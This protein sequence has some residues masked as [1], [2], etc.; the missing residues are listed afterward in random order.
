MRYKILVP[1]I[2]IALI[3]LLL[4]SFQYKKYLD[5][6]FFY[7]EWNYSKI[8]ESEPNNSPEMFHN[9]GQAALKSFLESDFTNRKI[10]QQSYDYFSWSLLLQEY[11]DTRFKYEF[12]KRLLE[13]Y[14]SENPEEEQDQESSQWEWSDTQQEPQNEESWEQTGQVSSW[15]NGRE[16][17]YFLNQQEE[18]Q[19]LSPRENQELQRSID[20]LKRDQMR[21]QQFYGK[22]QQTTPFQEA[23]DSVFW[24]IDRGW[25]KDW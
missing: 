14:G 22:Q 11:E 24:I 10:L 4:G 8:L 9:Y 20:R 17:E 2:G 19:P 7:G 18:I 1:I 6:V 23:F 25:E 3:V 13:L 21:N 5:F 12:T 15:Q 16:S